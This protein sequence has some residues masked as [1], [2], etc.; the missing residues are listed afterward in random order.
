MFD[1]AP[2]PT[3]DCCGSEL[4]DGDEGTLVCGRV[5]CTDCV[6]GTK[7]PVAM[8]PTAAEKASIAAWIAPRRATP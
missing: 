3:C 6:S 4:V 8:P 5:W 7:P 1:F 2:L